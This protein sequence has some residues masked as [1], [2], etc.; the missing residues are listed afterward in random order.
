[1]GLALFFAEFPFL[2]GQASERDLLQLPFSE[3][4]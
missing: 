3:Q 1:M 2:A 4:K